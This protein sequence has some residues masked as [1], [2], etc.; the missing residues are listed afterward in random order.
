MPRIKAVFWDS[1]NTLIDTFA[2]HWAKHV[3]V[4]ARH[5]ITL[6]SSYKQRIHENNGIQNWQWL[7]AELGLAVPQADYIK[8]IDTYFL[9]HSHTLKLRGAVSKILDLCDAKHIPQMVVS[10]GRRHS[11]EMSHAATNIQNRFLF[12]MCKEDYD[13]RKPEPA[14]FLT[15]LDRYHK[16]TGNIIQAHECLAIDDD[17]LGVE[18]AKRAGMMTLYRPTDLVPQTCVFADFTA[19][20]DDTF[21][22]LCRTLLA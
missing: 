20:N 13:G 7:S 16:M 6:D 17:P 3:A 4:L 18:S 8:E 11:V 9:E 19:H 1:D 14:P 2:L 5:G 12:L 10:N 15:A 21:V 22:E